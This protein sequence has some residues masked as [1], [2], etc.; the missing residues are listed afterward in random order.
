MLDAA[1]VRVEGR[2]KDALIRS[3][4]LIRNNHLKEKVK[5]ALTG[6][7]PIIHAHGDLIS[8]G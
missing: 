5:S 1:F 7:L 2:V 8:I 4:P 6:I 3:I